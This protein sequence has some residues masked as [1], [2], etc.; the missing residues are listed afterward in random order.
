MNNARAQTKRT[1]LVVED[2]VPIQLIVRTVLEMHD[3]RVLTAGDGTTAMQLSRQH[4]GAIDLVITDMKLPGMTGSEFVRQLL[5][6]RPKLHVLYISGELN[7]EASLVGGAGT[8]RFLG[9]PFT[10]KELVAAVCAMLP[11]ALAE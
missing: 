7:H 1:V 4:E 10:P 2:E 3:Y 5:V 9:K 8:A 11:V 6:E